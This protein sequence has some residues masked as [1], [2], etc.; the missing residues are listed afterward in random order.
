MLR[1]L[2]AAMEG[3]GVADLTSWVALA[4]DDARARGAAGAVQAHLARLRDPSTNGAYTKA[5]NSKLPRAVDHDLEKWGCVACN[6]CVTVCPNDAF[7]QLRPS[8]A[9]NR[10]TPAVLRADRAVQRLRQLPGVLPENGDPAVIKRGLFIDPERFMAET[11]QAY[12]ITARATA[13]TWSSP[14]R[15]A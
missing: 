2:A 12:L 9:S 7:F 10:G 3:A 13:S 1:S 4:Q 5:G 6:F 8:T 14:T 15:P 11:E